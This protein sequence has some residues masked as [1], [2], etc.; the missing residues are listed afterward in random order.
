[1]FSVIIPIYNAQET[2]INTVNNIIRALRTNEYEL[3]LINDGS[4][5]NTQQKINTFHS[6]NRVKIITQE[7]KGVSAARNV[8]IE[9]V[10]PHSKYITFIDDSDSISNNFFDNNIKFLE[11]FKHVDLAACQ[12]ERVINGVISGHSLNHRFI[13]N[14]RE[15]VDIIDDFKLI[16]F[17]IGGAVFRS[18]LF[19]KDGF[20]FD[21]T[22]TFWEDAKLINSIL[23]EKKIYGLVR[24]SIY[25]YDR[26]NMKS[27]SYNSW[28]SIDRYTRH[29]RNNYLDLIN[30]SISEFGEVIDYV[31]FVIATHFIQYVIETNKNFIVS[32]YITDNKEFLN[33]AKLIFSYIDT[34]IIDQLN[35]KLFY[36]KVLYELKDLEFKANFDKNKIKILGQRYDFLKQRFEFTLT[37]ESEALSDDIEIF[38]TG[39]FEKKIPANLISYKSYKEPIFKLENKYNKLY[40]VRVTVLEAF[41]DQSFY[42][43]DYK[44]DLRIDL[45][46]KSLASRFLKL[47]KM[48]KGNL[49]I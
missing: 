4:T 19:L 43:K 44:R 35:A 39:F 18:K 29:M 2:I 8:G 38:K 13:N 33:T 20:R 6:N 26:N 24:G 49:K 28:N 5:D 14:D 7:N 36:K 16:H 3:I 15:I 1:M 10:S 12:I 48:K 32:K 46:S 45:K 22:I 30:K 9:N 41:F 21:E 47:F 25:F 23:L 34:K 42:I 40:G 37:T 17:H 27:L 11:K 31:Q